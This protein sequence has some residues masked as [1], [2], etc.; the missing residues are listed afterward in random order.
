MRNRVEIFHHWVIDL[1][2][3]S[4]TIDPIYIISK[5]YYI[6]RSDRILIHVHQHFERIRNI[7]PV[8]EWL[9]KLLLHIRQIDTQCLWMFRHRH[10]FGVA[11]LRDRF[12][13][14]QEELQRRV[15]GYFD[16]IHIFLHVLYIGQSVDEHRSLSEELQKLILMR[17]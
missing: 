6:L 9:Q 1:F 17:R 8:A 2:R 3:Y 12:G 10:R 7:L 4:S 16:H 13:I 11:D 14:L 5:V 15:C